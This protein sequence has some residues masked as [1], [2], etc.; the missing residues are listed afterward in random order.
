MVDKSVNVAVYFVHCV[1]KRLVRLMVVV[2]KSLVSIDTR[3]ISPYQP[4]LVV[5][6]VSHLGMRVVV[7]ILEPMPADKILTFISRRQK[8][9]VDALRYLKLQPR[10]E[11]ETY[12]TYDAGV[13]IPVLVFNALSE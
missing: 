10:I 5:G 8:E 3:L 12:C 7:D 9:T 2:Y 6:V 11:C 13:P 4:S 1:H